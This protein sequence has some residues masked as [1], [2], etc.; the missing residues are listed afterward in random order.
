MLKAFGRVFNEAVAS[1]TGS[2]NWHGDQP[3]WESAASE[4]KVWSIFCISTEVAA[5]EHDRQEVD[6][7]DNPVS[8]CSNIMKSLHLL[9][10]N[11]FEITSN[12]NEYYYHDE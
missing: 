10:H 12:C 1:H 4:E 7:H 9:D 3:P 2:N 6:H 11:L 5:K 8:G